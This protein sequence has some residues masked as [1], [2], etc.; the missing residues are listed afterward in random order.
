MLDTLLNLK[1]ILTRSRRNLGTFEHTGGHWTFQDT[2]PQ[3]TEI[4]ALYILHNL[5]QSTALLNAL[6]STSVSESPADTACGTGVSKLSCS[7][8]NVR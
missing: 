2:P 8:P 4:P 5:K 1:P 3:R 7:Q 6:S